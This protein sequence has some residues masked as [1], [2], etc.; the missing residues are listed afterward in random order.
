VL[1]L[2]TII[3]TGC[4]WLS[5]AQVH[6]QLI[7]MLVLMPAQRCFI[8]LNLFPFCGSLSQQEQ[9]NRKRERVMSETGT[10]L[11][12]PEKKRPKASQQPEE[13]EAPKQFT[14]F[15]YSKFNFK[16]FAGKIWI[17]ATVLQAVEN[18]AS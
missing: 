12:K 11:P 8:L 5:Q 17:S 15:D 4:P 2:P 1:S 10:E 18:V 7:S 14:P 9:A 3:A 13:L 16:V 6:Q